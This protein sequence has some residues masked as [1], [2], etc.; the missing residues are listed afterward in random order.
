MEEYDV[1]VIGSGPGGYVAAIRAGQLGMKAAVVERSELGGVCLNWGCIPS[2]ALLKNAEVLSYVQHAGEYGI[3]IDNYDADFGK[4]IDRSRK[5]VK[6][7]TDGIGFLLKKNNVDVFEGFGTL[8]SPNQVQIERINKT[9]QT[10]NVIIATGARFRDLPN[11]PFDGRTVITSREALELREVPEKVV[12]V[13]GGAT[14]A[15]FAYLWSKYGAEVTIVELMPHLVPNEDVEISQALERSFRRQ[16]IKAVTG[17]KVDSVQISGSKA[18]VTISSEKEPL[19]VE[20]DKVLVAVG[21]QGNIENIGLEKVGVETER[22]YVSVNEVLQT[23]V[24]NIYAIGD[25]TGKMLLA[26]VA[27]AQGVTAVEHIA[28]LNPPLLDYDLMPRATYCKPQIASFGLTEAQAKEQGHDVKIGKFP[29]V[30]SG[31]AL[32][33]GDTEG[34]VKVVV[35]A[36]IGDILG[37]HMIGSEV[38]ELLGELGMARLLESTNKELGWL[39]HPHPTISETIKEAALAADGEAVHV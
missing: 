35:D 30:A 28:G 1:I 22:N 5:V 39:V 34:L 26:H 33:L 32:A 24:G 17:A 15:E 3:D 8:I 36:E 4:A 38:T 19:E 16:G 29:M 11:L 21:N 23:S 6:K 31:K 12:I 20:C 27:S 9:L 2:K 25:V 7:L 18:K 14:G 13:G 10:K 37:A